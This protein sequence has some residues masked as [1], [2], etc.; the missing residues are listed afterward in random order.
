[1]SAVLMQTNSVF[2]SLLHNN[3]NNNTS[4]SSSATMLDFRAHHTS[5]GGT[6]NKAG[7]QGGGYASAGSHTINPPP[8]VSILDVCH[9]KIRLFGGAPVAFLGGLVA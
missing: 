4:P 3:N 1:M 5:G 9:R 7:A 8:K 6:I 2:K